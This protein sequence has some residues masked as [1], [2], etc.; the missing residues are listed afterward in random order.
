LAPVSPAE[1]STVSAE[2]RATAQT[3]AANAGGA[4]GGAE[5]RPYSSPSPFIVILDEVGYYCVDGMAIMAA[6]A[7]GSETLIA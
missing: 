3:G 1:R 7:R 5:A 2:T 6:Q 4:G